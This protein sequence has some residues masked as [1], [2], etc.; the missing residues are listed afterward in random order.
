MN[1]TQSILRINVERPYN[2]YNLWIAVSGAWLITLY[3]KRNFTSTEFDIR[4]RRPSL[5]IPRMVYKI[6]RDHYTYWEISRIARG[7]P[8]TFTYSKWDPKAVII[9]F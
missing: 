3:V 5:W 9:F 6:R 4:K 7:L 8:K 1:N 2:Y